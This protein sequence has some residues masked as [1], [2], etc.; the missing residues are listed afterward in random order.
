MCT[1]PLHFVSIVIQF[2][3]VGYTVI[4]KRMKEGN[5][6]NGIRILYIQY[7]RPH[8]SMQARL[9]VKYFVSAILFGT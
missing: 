9:H 1:Q 5:T 3:V 7:V 4:G 6:I 2:T 8:F